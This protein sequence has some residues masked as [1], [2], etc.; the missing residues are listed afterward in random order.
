[1][2]RPSYFARIALRGGTRSKA[3][4][5]RPP[6]LL[7]RPPSGPPEL[8]EIEMTAHPRP[9]RNAP[10]AMERA[11]PQSL[12]AEPGPQAGSVDPEL[13]AE[14][15]TPPRALQA[16]EPPSAVPAAIAAPVS[17]AAPLALGPP[18]GRSKPAEGIAATPPSAPA[19]G[20]LPATAGSAPG[21]R[22]RAL[23]VDSKAFEP[24]P[25]R[26]STLIEFERA[27]P[28]ERART[29]ARIFRAI[30]RRA[31]HRTAAAGPARERSA[32]THEGT[33]RSSEPCSLRHP[34]RRPRQRRCRQSCISA[35]WRCASFRQRR[36]SPPGRGPCL[37]RPCAERTERRSR[38]RSAYLD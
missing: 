26:A 10:I 5:L 23:P 8:Q 25:A 17:S 31:A 28:A 2:R 36:R 15:P 32:Q 24:G 13:R 12:A 7:F 22:S 11:V 14:E 19:S 9:P 29:A 18:A 16:A 3:S 37:E 20:R 4:V 35:R 27:R 33:W 30:S 1:M 21:T 34:C 6:K 38:A